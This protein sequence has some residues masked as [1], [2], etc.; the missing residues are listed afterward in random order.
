MNAKLCKR[1]RKQARALAAERGWPQR[2]LLETRVH[3][4]R[5]RFLEKINPINGAVIDNGVRL[6]HT[7]VNNPRSERGAYQLMKRALKEVRHG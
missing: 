2:D 1:L 7:S 6:V 4:I 3:G 5:Y